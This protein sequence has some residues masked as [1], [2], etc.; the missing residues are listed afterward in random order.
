MYALDVCGVPPAPLARP[1]TSRTAGRGNLE[2]SGRY[3][4]T[5]RETGTVN[6]IQWTGVCILAVAG[7]ITVAEFL[8]WVRP[9]R[10]FIRSLG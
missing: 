8:V 10:F 1:I 4:R 7:L 6:V 2:P 3:D 5:D 9:Q